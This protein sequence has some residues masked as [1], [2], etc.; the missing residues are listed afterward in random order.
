MI[1]I[2][3]WL[4]YALNLIGFVVDYKLILNIR[5]RIIYDN[6][7]TIINLIMILNQFNSTKCL[8]ENTIQ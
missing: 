3:R 1:C 8:E 7:N 6:I 4:H 2:V 5:D